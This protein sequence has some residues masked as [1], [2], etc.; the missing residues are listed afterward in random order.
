MLTPKRLHEPRAAK[1]HLDELL[2]D[3]LKATFPASDPVAIDVEVESPRLEAAIKAGSPAAK[4]VGMGQS[5]E[6][7][8]HSGSGRGARKAWSGDMKKFMV[9]YMASGAEFE[10]MMKSSTPEQQKK[11]MEMW[12]KWMNENQKSLIDGGA[13]LGKTKRVDSKGVSSTKNEIGGYS[14]IQAESHDV[15]SKIFDHN[16]PHLQMPGT[17]VEIIEVMPIPG[18]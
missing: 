6:A 16:H 10:K 13:P 12:M 5:A 15:A 1:A 8:V 18:M 14:I 11:G 4:A 17:W 9:L 2:D 3:A 7:G